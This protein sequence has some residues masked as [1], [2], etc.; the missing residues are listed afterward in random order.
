MNNEIV[1]VLI[2]F[3]KTRLKGNALITDFPLNSVFNKEFK[4]NIKLLGTGALLPEV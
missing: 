1:E 2:S 4:Y 3:G